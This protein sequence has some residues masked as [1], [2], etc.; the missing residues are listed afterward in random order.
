M[1]NS[2]QQKLPTARS[3]TGLPLRDYTERVLADYFAH[4]NGHAPKHLHEWVMREVEEPLLRIVMQHSDGNLSRAAAML[5]IT[6]ATLRKKL[7]EF[8]LLAS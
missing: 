7:R 4:L 3:A 1:P 6:R 8:G 5:G 2:Q